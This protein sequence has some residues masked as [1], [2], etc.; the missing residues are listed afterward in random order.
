MRR[1]LVPAL[2]ISLLLS[3]CGESGRGLQRRVEE[4]RERFASAEEIT[5]TADIRADLGKE[6]FDC[7]LLCTAG[8]DAASVEVMAP[9]SVAGIRAQTGTD[10]LTLEY[11]G[12]SLAIGAIGTEGLSPL[13]APPLLVSAL[14]TGVP[15]HCWTERD[16]DRA[17]IAAETYVTD[18][19]AL[20]VWYDAEELTPVHCEFS[21][22]GTVVLDC[23]IREF[24]MR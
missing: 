12:V 8:P 10:G 15:E 13:S 6:V 19:A 14:R 2:M 5:F 17:L 22:D 11:D 24:T 18:A 21:R 16:G 20:T 23:G 7:T 9:E 4:Q 1:F 3:G